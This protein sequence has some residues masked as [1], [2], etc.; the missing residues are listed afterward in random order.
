LGLF[1]NPLLLIGLSGVFIPFIIEWLFRRRPRQVSLPTLRYLLLRKEQ[2]DMR[3]QNRIL[4]LIRALGCLLIALSVARPVL[5]NETTGVSTNK[6][7]I[8]LIDGTASMGQQVGVTTAFKTAT[9]QTSDYISSLPKGSKVSLFVLTHRVETIIENEIDLSI[10]AGRLR[11]LESSSGSAPIGV[12]LTFLQK[13]IE[14]NKLEN[15]EIYIFSDFQKIT[16][17]RSEKSISDAAT[18]MNDLANKGTL[19][20]IDMGGGGEYNLVL[21]EFAPIDPVL[22]VGRLVS[23]KGTVDIVGKPPG[24]LKIPVNFVVNGI[25]K[26]AREITGPGRVDFEFRFP[27]AGEYLVTIEI[28]GDNFATDNKRSYL[29]KVSEDVRVLLLDKKEG[30]HDGWFFQRAIDPPVKKGQDRLSPFGVKVVNTSRAV[31][32][33]FHEYSIIALSA[34][35]D[36]DK[37]LAAKLNNFVRDGGGLIVFGGD[38]NAYH[39]NQ[40][41]YKDGNGVLPYKLD[42]KSRDLTKGSISFTAS[43]HPL[44]AS[45][46]TLTNAIPLG[47]IWPIALKK[48]ESLME[49]VDVLAHAQVG[50]EMMPL[51]IAKKTGRGSCVYIGTTA[52]INWNLFAGDPVYVTFFQDLLRYLIGNPDKGVNLNIG[53]RFEEPVLVSAQHLLLNGPGR[54]RERLTPKKYSSEIDSPLKVRFENTSRNG[55]YVIDTIPEVMKR[56]RFVV[57]ASDEESDLARLSEDEIRGSLGG[58]SLTW[59]APDDDTLFRKSEGKAL[60]DL[61]FGILWGLVILLITESFLAARFGLRRGQGLQTLTNSSSGIKTT[62]SK[63]NS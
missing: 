42:S 17:A 8:F 44:A 51:I 30:I 57:N 34:T 45:F 4:L 32:E 52:G 58:A 16:W 10:V 43:S 49:G 41:L 15:P 12:G 56:R 9:R 33:N 36:L 28:E 21:K 24:D 63:E 20:L 47:R 53:E 19:N 37:S 50:E 22:A 25:K 2:K 35:E 55:E 23:F 13:Y 62:I 54:M 59:I 14:E 18:A 1:Q 61:A 6:D 5:H 31:Y 7:M 11:P 26:N 27:K 3:R 60:T 29:C 48:G 38:I 39:Y 40:H 46:T